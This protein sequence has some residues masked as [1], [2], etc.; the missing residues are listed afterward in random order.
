MF[1][2][3]CST[4]GLTLW[5]LINSSAFYVTIFLLCFIDL[6]KVPKVNSKNTR[7]QEISDCTGTCSE[8]AI[9]SLE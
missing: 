2:S 8:S 9:E 3:D 5:S 1:C 6:L 7:T 4:F